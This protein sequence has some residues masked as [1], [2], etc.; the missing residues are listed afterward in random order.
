MGGK[1]LQLTRHQVLGDDTA[2]ASVN[3]DHV[4][5]LIAGVQLHGT[6]G[7]LAAQC[8]VSA[9]QQLLARLALGVECTRYLC[10]TERTVG[11]RAAVFAGEGHALCHAL[12]DDVVRYFGQAVNV[13]LTCAV[14]TALHG[15][16]EQAVHRVAVVLIILGGIDTSLCGDGVCAARRV[17]DAEVEYLE[18]HFAKRSGC[19]GS[20]QTRTHHDDVEA[21]LIGGVY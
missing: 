7:H 13:G 18:T 5:H 21:A 4:L 6:G 11:Q 19:T 10:A 17:L 3:D 16:V 9:Q 15:V 14:V 12:V 8:R 2:C 20:C 1:A